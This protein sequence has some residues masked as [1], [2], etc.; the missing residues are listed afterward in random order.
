MSIVIMET[1]KICWRYG[2]LNPETLDDKPEFATELPP[3]QV[4]YNIKSDEKNKN[5]VN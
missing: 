4:N 2:E 3:T 5:I 1:N